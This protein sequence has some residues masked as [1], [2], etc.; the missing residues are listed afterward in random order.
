ME[1]MSQPAS[2]RERKKKLTRDSIA[3]TTLQLVVEKGLDRVTVEEIARIAFVSPRTVSNYFAGK[4]EAIVAAGEST[5]WDSITDELAGRPAEETPLE[6]VA[7]IAVGYV[8]SLTPEQLE[9]N[10]Q[11]LALSEQHPS[12]KPYL[13]AH[14]ETI[15]S[16]LRPALADRTGTDLSADVY[17][18]LLSAT[19]VAAIRLTM[20]HWTRSDSADVKHLTKTIRSAFDQLAAGLPAP[21]PRRRV[22]SRAAR[23]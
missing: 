15:E 8:K 17:P 20:S 16:R 21:P 23:P 1:A 18:W 11:K 3:D 4:E 13:V 14:Y 19:A 9:L 22:T 5:Y 2:L 7:A 12:I 10:R 6:A